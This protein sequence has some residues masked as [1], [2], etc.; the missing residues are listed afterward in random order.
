MKHGKMTRIVISFGACIK[1]E[2]AKVETRE[3]NQ[4]TFIV[5]QAGQKK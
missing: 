1:F 4:L 2:T 5:N 3:P